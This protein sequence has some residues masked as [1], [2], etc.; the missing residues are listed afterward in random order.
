MA[1]LSTPLG[2]TGVDAD[3]PTGFPGGGIGSGLWER[4]GNGGR[5]STGEEGSGGREIGVTGREVR[6]GFSGGGRFNLGLGWLISS[7]EDDGDDGV[8]IDLGCWFWS[9]CTTG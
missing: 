2:V 5:V 7:L 4:V 6:A 8:D 3:L 1:P 9:C